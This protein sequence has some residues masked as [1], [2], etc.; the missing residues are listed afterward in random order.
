MLKWIA[1]IIMTIDHIGY[2]FY[3]HLSEPVYYALRIAGRLAFPIFA[4]HIVKGFS[5]TSNP[6]KYIVRMASWAVIAHFAISAAGLWAG[7]QTSLF[8][9]SWT[10][11]MVLFT[12]AIIM[13]AGYDM[14]MRSYHDMVASMTLACSPPA[15][16]KDPRYDVKVNPGGLTMSPRFGILMGILMMLGSF[17]F[18]DVLNADYGVYGLLMVLL[19]N[20]SYSSED[21]KVCLSTLAGSL[22][23]LNAAYIAMAAFAGENI[24]FSLIQT[25]SVLAVLLFNIIP[26]PRRKPNFLSKYFF[27][28]YYPAHI[29]ALIFISANL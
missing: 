21:N 11:V 27:Y 24:R 1:L 25:F 3:P 17:W 8:D 29:V 10:N 13:L 7:R 19:I 5:R 22:L 23:L 16:I 14:A 20:I 18:V 2:Y 9:I 4:F 26:D 12:F 28:I 15:K 6:G